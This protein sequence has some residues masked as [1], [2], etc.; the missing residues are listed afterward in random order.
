[1]TGLLVC[2]PNE[3]H[4]TQTLRTIVIQSLLSSSL[5]DHPKFMEATNKSTGVEEKE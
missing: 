4:K 5:C 2:R 3:T 1:M